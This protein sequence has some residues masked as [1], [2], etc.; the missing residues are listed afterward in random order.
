MKQLI[1]YTTI[2]FAASALLQAQQIPETMT[3]RAL[4]A[5]VIQPERPSE[6]VDFEAFVALAQE[7]MPYRLGRLIDLNTFQRFASEE[8]T[9]ILDTRTKEMYE[10]KHIKGA[11]HL[12]FSDFN[13]MSLANLI[14]SK[15]ARILIYCNNNFDG[16][17]VNFAS[18]VAPRLTGTESKK[19]VSLALNIP[20]FINLYG[21]GYT[22]IYELQ[23]L[24]DVRDPRLEFEGTA[25]GLQAKR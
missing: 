21:Y 5:R 14:P 1:F 3:R 12:N 9:I 22:N 15:E 16:D 23:S 19:P 20:T 24:L 2:L 17:Q 11:V 10:S 13:E 8:N 25:F 6:I 7:V 4:V 18:K